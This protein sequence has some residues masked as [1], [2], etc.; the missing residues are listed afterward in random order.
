[1]SYKIIFFLRIVLPSVLTILLFILMLFVIIIPNTEDN[2]LNIK[3]QMIKEL[4]NSAWNIINEAHQ[5]EINNKIT[6]DSAQNIAYNLIRHLKYG[7]DNKD[8]FWITDMHPNMIM[9][10][11]RVDLAGKDLSGFEDPHGK[12]L[13]VEC[14]NVVKKDNS[15]FVDYMW[16]WKDD[17]LHIVPKLSFVKAFEPWQW[18]VGTG[19]YIEDV[20]IEISNMTRKILIIS[21]VISVLIILLLYFILRQNLQ[22]EAKRSIAEKKLIDSKERYKA[23]VGATTEGVLL[24]LENKVVYYNSIF[25]DLTKI[26]FNKLSEDNFIKTLQDFKLDICLNKDK[27]GKREILLNDKT[28]CVLVN[29]SPIHISGQ[30]G[31]IFIIKNITTQIEK[32]S[33]FEN[34]LKVGYFKILLKSRSKFVKVNNEFLKLTLYNRENIL[35]ISPFSILGNSKIIKE[36][37]NEFNSLGK[38]SSRIIEVVTP[39]KDKVFMFTTLWLSKDENS[40]NY[41]EGVIMNITD[42]INKFNSLQNSLND[43]AKHYYILFKSVTEIALTPDSINMYSGQNDFLK[44]FYE[45]NLEIALI[46]DNFNNI[47]GYTYKEYINQNFKVDRPGNNAIDFLISPIPVI[48]NSISIADAWNELKIKQTPYLFIKNNEN[49]IAGF[50]SEKIILKSLNSWPDFIELKVNNLKT[51]NDLK[52]FNQSLPYLISGMLTGFE[53]APVVSKILS[54]VTNIITSKI[55]I[56]AIEQIGPPPVNFAFIT[57]GSLGREERT[58]IIDQD[59]ALIFQD[60]ENNI[61][62]QKYFIKLSEVICDNLHLIGYSYCPGNIMAKNDKWCQPLSKWKVYFQHWINNPEPQNVLDISIFFDFKHLYGDNDLTGELRTFVADSIKLNSTLLFHMARSILSFKLPL[63]TFGSLVLEN[64]GANTGKFNVKSIML[65]IIMLARLY[66]LKYNISAT[67]TT[68]RMTELSITEMFNKNQPLEMLSDYY[69]LMYIRL[70]S[71]IKTDIS[72]LE[73]DNF[74][75]IKNMSTLEESMLKKIVVQISQHIAILNSDYSGAG[76][77]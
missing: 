37:T 40:S 60:T 26:D 53:S 65:P 9:H 11:F 8:Y 20:R 51:V 4:T 67:N 35:N 54:R 2:L 10:P 50:I 1:M 43:L 7:D 5:L 62:N 12:K 27:P 16:Q 47:I 28:T 48:E 69:F 23:L 38:I 77:K 24:V 64:S 17:S 49:K 21:T 33:E 61:E 19:I 71:F 39:N 75:D 36:I 72:N 6:K 18:I 63:S 45:N 32:E 29:Y 14:V 15:G 13:F 42:W 76:D 55:I 74:I 3:K 34:L 22:L 46:N 57:L 44:Y 73:N 66:S 52:V 58:F 31:T 41:C 56:K 70:K 30:T 25:L 68:Q 59:N